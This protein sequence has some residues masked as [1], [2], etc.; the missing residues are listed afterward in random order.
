MSRAT[1]FPDYD[2]MRR[3]LERVNAAASIRHQ[4]ALP[5]PAEP[6]D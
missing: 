3:T 4:E 6:A 2:Q 1:T 5:E